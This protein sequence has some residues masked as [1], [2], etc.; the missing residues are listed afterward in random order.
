MTIEKFLQDEI[1]RPRADK[2]RALVVYDP[3]GLY[4]SLVLTMATPRLKVIDAQASII[5]ARSA[6][7][8][9]LADLG[10][11]RIDTLI[12][13]TPTPRPLT[14]EGKKLDPFA[15][16]AAVG[17]VFP[18]GA[19]DAY[20]ALCLRARPEN[21][22]GIQ[23]LFEGQEAPAFTLINALGGGT[24]FVQLQAALDLTRPDARAIFERLLCPT[25]EQAERLRNL[26]WLPEAKQCIQDVLG[27]TAPAT[28][29]ASLQDYLWLVL[30]FSEFYFDSSQVDLPEGLRTVPRA[31]DEA[32]PFVYQLCDG[33]R[34]GGFQET[35][36]VR[37]NRLADQ[38]GLENQAAAMRSLG[39]RD[40]FAFEESYFL[41]QFVAAMQAQ[42][43]PQARGFV[44][45]RRRSMWINVEAYQARKV[46]WE[47]AG[48]AVDLL[49]KMGQFANLPS[50][51]PALVEHYVGKLYQVDRLHRY[52][53]SVLVDRVEHHQGLDAVIA[54]AREAYVRFT[55]RLHAA[56][57]AAVTAA[58]WP[59]R[60]LEYVEN[61]ELFDKVVEPLLE[62]REPNRVA[63]LLVDA[64]RFE[65]ARD[66]EQQL[67]KHYRVDLKVACA[68]L[69]T[70]TEIG[71]A[72]LMPKAK[73]NLSL[74]L[75]DGELTTYL[76][77]MVATDP[78]KRFAWMKQQ[79][80]DR[81]Q[82]I[83]LEDLL[84]TRRPIIGENINLLVVRD[85][86][87]DASAEKSEELTMRIIPKLLNN[88]QKGLRKLQEMGFTHAVIATD[89]GF[90][91]NMD[92]GAG[93]TCEYP[94]GE[95]TKQTKRCVLGRGTP[96]TANAVL[97]RTLL[98]IP[99]EFEHLATPRAFTSYRSA[100]GYFHEGISLQENLLPRM[101]VTLAAP[102]AA[103]RSTMEITAL[104]KGGKTKFVTTRRPFID[105][106]WSQA[107]ILAT[108]D[109]LRFATEAE[110]RIV[111][112]DASGKEVGWMVQGDH[113]DPATGL[114][115]VRP[116][117]LSSF[118]LRLDE[119]FAGPFTVSIIDP[120]TQ[121]SY[122]KLE[123]ETQFHR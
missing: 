95:W 90:M 79:K 91:L 44:E 1:L 8:L 24:Q 64:L 39:K 51:L 82:D 110:L 105:V 14:D 50:D 74:K 42:L 107:E 101:V 112:L 58:G 68:Q 106:I 29:L 84:T 41:D 85:S 38:L 65:L 28:D 18:A 96:D 13:W 54:Q 63:Y 103:A 45:N 75:K 32:Q 31:A 2:A 27:V 5:D 67:I 102:A 109:E 97:A 104:Y 55:Q 73:G 119:A 80:G 69:P 53:E 33:L 78:Q 23:R 21:A 9:A 108:E 16:V 81:C 115:R 26:G 36:I 49:E 72:S 94:E 114:L 12:I 89:H 83:H 34:V 123:L 88:V 111:A 59:L 22:V 117:Q 121:Q 6:A 11:R 25:P 99:G 61:S 93:T 47:V 98:G 92:V 100:R 60:G 15:A 30:L 43:W 70:Y 17:E 86:S 116:L 71:M 56:T 77:D 35:Y 7:A 48:R 46:E 3:A 40:T 52:L 37:A 62:T 113:T 76:G 66:L 120:V 118:C 20:K 10:A 87:I 4:H 122:A 19:G 57:L